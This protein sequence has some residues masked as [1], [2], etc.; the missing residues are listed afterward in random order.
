MNYTHKDLENLVETLF[1]LTQE[2]TCANEC[3]KDGVYQ[4]SDVVM[5]FCSVGGGGREGFEEG[6][7]SEAG[8]S[9]NQ[10][11]EQHITRQQL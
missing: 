11:A 4:L 2:L 10:Q 6:V 8:G 1:V 9:C 3:H 5:I 7:M